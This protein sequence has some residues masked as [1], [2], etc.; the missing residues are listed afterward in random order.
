LQKKAK[1]TYIG[2]PAL[3]QGLQNALRDLGVG[4]DKARDFS[5]HPAKPHL[6]TLM[7]LTKAD[8]SKHPAATVDL[9]SLAMQPS[10][11]QV[12]QSLELR[13]TAA[14]EQK[15][16]LDYDDVPRKRLK[17][18]W[19]KS[20]YRLNIFLRTNVFSFIICRACACMQWL[21]LVSSVG[22]MTD[23]LTLQISM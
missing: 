12:L 1:E 17:A 4:T 14:A 11:E 20:T 8:E 5:D 15:R 2:N 6:E 19:C 9:K 21:F 13:V 3:N 18:R 22:R 10:D 16:K 7:N 23:I